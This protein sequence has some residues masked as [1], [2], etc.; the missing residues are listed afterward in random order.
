MDFTHGVLDVVEKL[1]VVA[2]VTY[3]VTRSGLFPSIVRRSLK[4][5]HS[6]I[7]AVKWWKNGAREEGL[8]G[9]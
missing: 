8:A 2:F 7:L 1:I 5:V 6:A 3:L 4:P 9:L